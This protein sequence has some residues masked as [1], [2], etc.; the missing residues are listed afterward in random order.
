MLTMD[1]EEATILAFPRTEE[2]RLLRDSDIELRGTTL[3]TALL[4]VNFEKDSFVY[5]PCLEKEPAALQGN[6]DASDNSTY[7][8]QLVLQYDFGQ[9][10]VERLYLE[11]PDVMGRDGI[12]QLFEGSIEFFNWKTKTYDQM[13]QKGTY[14]ADE[15]ADY[16]DGENCLTIRYLSNIVEEYSYKQ[17]LP[18][19]A[20]TGRE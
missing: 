14:T 2:I 8:R 17:L 18:R 15:I 6:Y 5:I 3:V 12:A 1:K 10:Q 20:A 11:W 7:V 9:L 4:Q 19:I 13:E 16:L